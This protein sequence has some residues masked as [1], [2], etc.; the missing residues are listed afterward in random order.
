MD[1]KHDK[2]DEVANDLDE[3]MTTVDELIEDP[4]EGVDPADITE[5]KQ[6]LEHASDLAD[7]IEDQMK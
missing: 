7:E 4:P 3:L 1:E 2:V 6:G 5:L